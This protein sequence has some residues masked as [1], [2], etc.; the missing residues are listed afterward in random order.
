[1]FHT[2]VASVYLNVAYVFAMVS[3]V[4]MVFLHVFQM[5]VLSVSSAFQTYVASEC[6]KS[7]SVVVSPSSPY[8]VSSL[9]LLLLERLG[10]C[11]PFPLFSMLVMFEVVGPA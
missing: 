3:S 10:I 9:C 5:N 2:Y 6:F 1:M 8:V 7:S 11:R 4:F